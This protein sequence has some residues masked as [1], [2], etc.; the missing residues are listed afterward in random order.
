M[1]QSIGVIGLGQIGGGVAANLIKAGYSIT[2]YDPKPEA[3]ERFVS[4]EGRPADSNEAI[5][6]ECDTVLTCLEAKVSVSAADNIL[7][8]KARREQTFIDH[9]TVPCPQT[10]RIGQAFLAKGCRYLDAPVSGGAQG[11]SAGTL[12]IFVGGD[13]ATAEDCWHIF[14]AAGDPEKVIY[15]GPVGMGQAAKV[16]QQLTSRFPDVARMEVMAFGLRAGL[17]LDTVMKALDVSPDS[18]DPY[19]LLCAAVREN[20]TDSLSG[21]FSEWPYYLQEVKARG[22]RLPMLEAMYDFCKDAET[23]ATDPVGRPM[24]SLWNE[25]MRY[26]DG[27]TPNKPDA[28]DPD[29]HRGA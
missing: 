6:D 2:G 19:A 4:Q 15:C 21:L 10:R 5:V 1:K 16:V 24:P 17:D 22:F 9:S 8:P 20:R 14:E 26:T 27:Q 11:A 28:G 3:M 12:R 25:L 23:V 13:S 29:V 7:L 18:N